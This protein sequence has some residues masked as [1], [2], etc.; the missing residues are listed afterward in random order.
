M[1]YGS[2]AAG[3]KRDFKTQY[4]SSGP[5]ILMSGG[6]GAFHQPVKFQPGGGMEEMEVRMLA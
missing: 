6:R 1:I 5:D 3:D 4:R 2:E